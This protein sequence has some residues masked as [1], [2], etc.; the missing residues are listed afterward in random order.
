MVKQKKIKQRKATLMNG[1]EV[2]LNEL[3][4]YSGW[5]GEN[6]EVTIISE[7]GDKL[8]TTINVST[9]ITCWIER[10]NMDYEDYMKK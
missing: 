6:D 7:K 8:L 4:R 3:E 10:E 5:K 9:L 2:D 1:D